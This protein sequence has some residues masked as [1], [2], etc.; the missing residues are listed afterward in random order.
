MERKEIIIDGENAIL[1]RLASYAAKQA[2]LGHK[3]TIINTKKVIIIGRR[4]DILSEFLQKRQK[5][6][7]GL[8]GPKY[9][10]NAERILKRTIRGMLPH[11]EGR[12]KEALGKI[13]CYSEIPANYMGKEAIKAGKEKRT[14]NVKIEELSN[15]LKGR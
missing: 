14:K 13:R 6:G 7:H 2:L 5:L 4:E 8:R 10:S 9:P 3:V 1:G 11:K 12:G 15:Y